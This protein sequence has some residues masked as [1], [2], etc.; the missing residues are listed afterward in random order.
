MSSPKRTLSEYF[1]MAAIGC[2]I[3]TWAVQI[4]AVIAIILSSPAYLIGT[5]LLLY[6]I[7]G[8]GGAPPPKG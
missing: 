7:F 3:L 6:W 4:L 2:A 5:A 1:W 8:R